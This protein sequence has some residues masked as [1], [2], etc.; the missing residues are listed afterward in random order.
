ME[1][2]CDSC[3]ITKCKEQCPHGQN[4]I[5]DEESP[6]SDAPVERLVIC[7]DLAKLRDSFKN[8]YITLKG[9]KNRTYSA[10]AAKRAY[11]DINKLC[12]KYGI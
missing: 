12:R 10:K 2:I 5:D 11:L 1:F 7:Q 3:K 9:L 8:R 6:R 4:H